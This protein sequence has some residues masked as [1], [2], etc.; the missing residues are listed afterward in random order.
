MDV[1]TV[2]V[3]FWLTVTPPPVPVTVTV[4]APSAVLEVAAKVMV[5]LPL[6]GEAM[7]VGEN[8]AVTLCGNPVMERAMADLN[9][10]C[11]AV[12]I[13]RE[14]DPPGATVTLVPA[15]VNVNPGFRTVTEML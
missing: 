4:E 13:L 6:P 7:L 3:I 2:S 5:L 12:V 1:A 8:F 14:I 10:F 11:A 15:G 9:P